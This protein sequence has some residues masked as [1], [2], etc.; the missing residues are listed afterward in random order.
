MRKAFSISIIFTLTL[1][2]VLDLSAQRVVRGGEPKSRQA[3]TTTTLDM[4]GFES[5]EAMTDGRGIF[6]RWQMSVERD[7]LGFDVFR[8][9]GRG[10]ARI[11]DEPVG[12]SALLYGQ[13]AVRGLRYSVY[14]PEG[15]SESIYFIESIG[16]DGRRLRTNGTPVVESGLASALVNDWNSRK[17]TADQNRNVFGA[18]LALTKELQ[19]EVAENSL[20]PDPDMHRWV[21]SQN[22]VRIGV[23]KEGFYRVTRAELQSGGFNVNADPALWQLYDHGVEQSIIVGPNGDYIEFFGRGVDTP[24]SD[25]RAYFL[26]NAATPGKRI[27]TRVVRPGTSNVV[28][29]SYPQTFKLRERTNFTNNIRNGH[30]ENFWGRIVTSSGSTVNFTLTGVDF[31]RPESTIKVAFQGFSQG[32]HSMA[33]TLNGEVLTPAASAGQ[34]PYSTTLTV[35]T[36]YLREGANS[37]LLRS[38]GPTGDSSFFD[39]LEISFNRRHETEQNK[40]YFFTQNNR[41]AKVSG[42]ASSDIRILDI[43]AESTPTELINLPIEVDGGTFFVNLPAARGRVLHATTTSSMLSPVSIVPFDP[44][45]IGVPNEAASLVIISYKNWMAEAEA[46]AN[47]RRGQGITV[48]TVNVDEI[49]DEFNY[50]VLSSDAVKLFLQYAYTSW[51][52]QPQYALIVGDAF[53]DPRNYRGFGYHNYIPTRSVNTIFTETPS[54]EYLAD[55]NSDGLAEIAVG[56]IPVRSGQTVTSTLAKVTNWEA[57]LVNPLDRGTL[58]AYDLPDGYDFEGM[59]NRIRNQLPAGA[60]ATMVGRGQQNS[61]ATLVSAINS[62]KFF[63]NYAGHGTTGGWA[64]LSF[65]SIFNVTCTNGQ[66]QCVNNPG[67]EAVYTMLTCLNGFFISIDNDSLAETLL[68]SNNGGGVAAWASTGLT[69]PDVQEVM[70]QRFYNQLGAGNIPRM[71]DLI[72]DAKSTIPGGIDVRLSWTLIGDPM[73]KV[74]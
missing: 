18:D 60:P 20:V 47:Y 25:T 61:Q 13:Q 45:L 71:G 9:D 26:I 59:S 73:L 8:V 30:A 33:M 50:G 31:S 32:V 22:G 28:A 48:K 66:T 19:T 63:V 46:W 7:N 6:V 35:P 3:A 54:D 38:A 16:M 29:Q 15:T 67:N 21:I 51:Q 4:T 49:Y 17:T 69:T 58:F 57:A 12:G 1:A 65:F 40:I 23:R 68:F 62:G 41:S 34:A 39:S 10:K 64:A 53:F 56:R 24:D 2:G 72:R 43:G 37:L 36:S 5:V 74:R 70:A 11:T 52:V 44:V 27:G 42:F 55:F 14:D